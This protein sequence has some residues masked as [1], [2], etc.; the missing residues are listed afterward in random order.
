[1]PNGKTTFRIS[2]FNVLGSS[3][4]KA[5]GNKPGMASGPE[6]MK[7]AVALLKKHNVDIVGFQEFQKDQYETFKKLAGG[8][9][10][11]FTG[12]IGK[13]MNTENSIA[14]KK[15]DWSLVKGSYID[16]PYFGGH[17]R[18]MP[19]VRLKNKHTGQEAYFINVHNP[20]DTAQHHG[21]EKYR[22]DATRREIALINKL[23]K[24]SG[25]PVF[26]VGDMNEHEESYQQ[27]TKGAPMTAAAVATGTKA[28]K[29]GIDWI[30]G[31]KGVQFSHYVKDRG[32]D[33]QRATDHPIVVADATIGK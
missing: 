30:Y 19:V 2:S 16:V 7:G 8:T 22:D 27:V 14:W 10:D 6:R 15:A 24:E 26:F 21:Q 5:S 11:V 9:Y 20:A 31:T 17:I 29:V 18:Q 4:T 33:V 1:V 13:K 28:S 3:H 25:L 23:T 32:A 12:K